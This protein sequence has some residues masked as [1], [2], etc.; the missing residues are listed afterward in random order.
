MS[1]LA[2]SKRQGI[3]IL[4][5]HSIS[6]QIG[7]THPYYETKTA[8]EVFARHMKFLR[9]NGYIAITLETASQSLFENKDV[10]KYVVITFDDGFRDFYSEA[11]PIVSELG[12]VVTM[13]LATGLIND[14]RSR[15]NGYEL[16]TWA[17]AR[18]LQRFG[19]RFGSHTVTHSDVEKLDDKQIV[20]EVTQSKQTLEDKLGVSVSSFAYP[21]AF[22]EHNS[23][24][25]QR[26]AE[27]LKN[28]GYENGVSTVIGRARGCHNRYLL[29][30]L[31][32]NTWDDLQLFQTKLE[33]GYDWLHVPQRM[34]KTFRGYSL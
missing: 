26:L 17:E 29:P 10:T 22:P 15:W 5:Y 33:G 19:V 27:T 3:P 25:T 18:E 21:N 23:A 4:M 11:F 20:W 13:F 6:A 2:D 30:R 28:I 24:F 9:D 1:R 8:L 34:Y 32:V 12:I 7:R 14:Q 31:P 16:M